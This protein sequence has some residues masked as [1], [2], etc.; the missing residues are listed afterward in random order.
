M[1]QVINSQEGTR[2]P[3]AKSGIVQ[4]AG[5]QVTQGRVMEE[6]KQDDQDS[7]GSERQLESQGA[8]FSSFPRG[9]RQV[10]ERQGGLPHITEEA[11]PGQAF[12]SLDPACPAP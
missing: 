5:Q 6:M 3:G 2:E 7:S 9:G 8:A 1:Q 10:C 12:L 4:G 11:K